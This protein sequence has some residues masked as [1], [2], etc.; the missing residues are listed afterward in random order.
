MSIWVWLFLWCLQQRHSVAIQC[1]NAETLPQQ[2]LEAIFT[3]VFKLI[4]AR[5][6]R[7]N[8]ASGSLDAAN[9]V[10]AQALLTVLWTVWWPGACETS[11]WIEVPC[12]HSHPWSTSSRRAQIVHFLEAPAFM[13]SL[14][15]SYTQP[16]NKLHLPTDPIT[17]PFACIA[18][19]LLQQDQ[20]FWAFIWSKYYLCAT[21]PSILKLLSMS[22]LPRSPSK[23][24]ISTLL[25]PAQKTCHCVA[26][27]C[28]LPRFLHV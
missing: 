17:C 2:E 24:Q 22:P 21:S 12:A 4:Q 6:G 20:I 14:F 16:L 10:E 26:H 27:R 19:L 15:V 23:V 8:V 13:S 9:F 11:M 25:L 5:T 18:V 1:V 3:G 7:L 28:Q